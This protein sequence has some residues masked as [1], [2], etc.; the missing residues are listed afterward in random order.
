MVA[1][2]ELGEQYIG[3]MIK[4]L[5]YLVYIWPCEMETLLDHVCY[6]H[7][8]SWEMETRSLSKGVEAR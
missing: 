4:S 6:R 3:M 1:E 2:G 7:R 8:Q 5:T